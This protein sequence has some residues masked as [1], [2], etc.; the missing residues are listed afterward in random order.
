VSASMYRARVAPLP[1]HVRE[2]GFSPYL[3]GLL[4]GRGKDDGPDA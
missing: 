2:H 1:W 3:S 4:G